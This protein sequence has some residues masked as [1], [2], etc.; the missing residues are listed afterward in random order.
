MQLR[1]KQFVFSASDLNNFLECVHLTQLDLLAVRGDVPAPSE[2]DPAAQL[3]AR[4]GDE[5][6]AR[7]LEGLIGDGR[8]VHAVESGPEQIADTIRAMEAGAEVIYQAAFE[9]D[10]WLGFADFLFRVETPSRL[11]D[12][13]YEAADAKLARSVKPYHVLQL[14][15]YSEQVTRI[16]DHEPAR[17]HVILGSGETVSLTIADY[18]AYYRSVRKRFIDELHTSPATYSLLCAHCAVCRWNE[19]CT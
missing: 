8:Q 11:G 9:H 3:L 18:A 2:N 5:Y 19:R 12:W 17:T 13:S 6:E 15:Y 16:Q 10:G 1:D 7:C 14:C 4:K